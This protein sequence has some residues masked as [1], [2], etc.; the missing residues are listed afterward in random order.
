MDADLIMLGLATHERYFYIIRESLGDMATYNPAAN[1]Q[2]EI[3]GERGHFLDKCTGEKWTRKPAA[4]PDAAASDSAATAAI[5]QLIPETKTSGQAFQ[6]LN[7]PILREY[8]TRELRLPMDLMASLSFPWDFENVIDDFI[9]LCMFVGNDFLPHLPSLDIKEGALEML[10]KAYKEMLPTQLGGYLSTAGVINLPRLGLLLQVVG[11]KENDIF[12]RR[13]NRAQFMA[14]KDQDHKRKIMGIRNDN[15]RREREQNK[16]G[17][18]Q[19]EADGTPRQ[20]AA[21]PLV[22]N[23]S[24]NSMN[25]LPSSKP[26]IHPSR[27]DPSANT[28]SAPLIS[29]ANVAAP[30]SA[31]VTEVDKITA[32][33][34]NLSAAALLRAKLLGNKS[35][36]A[37]ATPSSAA[38]A[39]PASQGDM[40][41]SSIPPTSR[42][43][44]DPIP[45]STAALSAMS[46]SDPH[47]DDTAAKANARAAQLLGQTM[48]GKRKSKDDSAA[49]EGAAAAAAATASAAGG[50]SSM[51]EVAAPVPTP[52]S[53]NPAPVPPSQSP[54]LELPLKKSKSESE[55]TASA[56]APA[57]SASPSEFSSSSSSA[58]PPAG[59]A[60]LNP[61]SSFD[62][63]E[64][65]QFGNLVRDM[66]FEDYF[67]NKWNAINQPADVVD[68]VQFG[69][70]GWK[71]RYYKLKLHIDID[72]ATRDPNGVEGQKASRVFRSYIEGL[73]WVMRYYFHGPASWSWFFIDHY[74]PMAED[75]AAFLLRE[76][77]M[78][79]ENQL[80]VKGMPFEPVGQLLAVLPAPS[81]HCVPKAAAVLMT[82]DPSS[83]LHSFYPRDFEND[84]NGKKFAHQAVALLPFIDEK[85][86]LRELARVRPQFDAEETARNSLGCEY[87]YVHAASPAGQQIYKQLYEGSLGLRGDELANIRYL[88]PA[89]LQATT[90]VP[91]DT[92][93]TK[94]LAGQ[95]R[96]YVGASLPSHPS[97]LRSIEPDAP[98]PI[99]RLDVIS[100][101]YDLPPYKPHVCHMLPN[102]DPV[103]PQLDEADF[104]TLV[105]PRNFSQ[106]PRRNNNQ[107]PAH[108]VG[109]YP[110]QSI[111]RGSVVRRGE[112]RCA[113][114]LTSGVCAHA[115]MFFCSRD[116]FRSVSSLLPRCPILVCIRSS[117]CRCLST[118][119]PAVATTCSLLLRRTCPCSWAACPCI[120]TSR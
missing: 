73:C 88:T 59:G 33:K 75:L 105:E 48:L 96:A 46:T 90:A 116:S 87:V 10:L 42:Q 52:S 37:S 28:S 82:D 55:S 62:P 36:A 115:L 47:E 51:G 114:A 81:R 100:A 113:V 43:Q 65:D 72:E 70:D 94:G 25:A 98:R 106:Q 74:A 41:T 6:F 119:R 109:G 39:V 45:A 3:C 64:T 76:G 34:A 69:V 27:A 99:Q 103:V 40:D 101:Q 44:S 110:Q 14:R 77:S 18:T 111:M 78:P 120:L 95:L 89:A 53:S 85:L 92:V 19:Y 57:P 107:G 108:V 91:F 71:Q 9:L 86:L 11:T 97:I 102:A 68:G 21:A 8:L 117:S 83:P 80:F 30:P 23:T 1:V 35:A 4:A 2:C 20:A 112:K 67:T 12:A 26:F 60:T 61:S 93:A 22:T 16:F 24:T 63:L 84:L 38:T 54:T 5:K 56:I 79:P 49:P 31:P 104:R 32:A 7:L 17:V 29:P 118:V 50:D 13:R 58:S 15:A 66:S